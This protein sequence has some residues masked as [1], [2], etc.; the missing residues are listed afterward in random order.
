MTRAG[1]QA[2]GGGSRQRW[3]LRLR[4]GDA[5]S[6]GDPLRSC[7]A[8][9]EPVAAYSFGDAR[10]LKF[11]LRSSLSPGLP[12]GAVRGRHC[13]ARSAPRLGILRTWKELLETVRRAVCG[14]GAGHH[15]RGAGAEIER[16]RRS[17]SLPAAVHAVASDRRR[18]TFLRRGSAG[19][20]RM[21]VLELAND[22]FPERSRSVAIIGADAFTRLSRLSSP[23]RGRLARSRQIVLTVPIS[24]RSQ[25]SPSSGPRMSAV[26][27]VEVRGPRGGLSGPRRGPHW[28]SPRTARTYRGP[29]GPVLT[30]PV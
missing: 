3:R 11:A 29:R 10:R 9:G 2:T 20:S 7:T 8:W 4:Q 23:R 24:H 14:L 13:P 15:D 27:A 17:R 1:S 5:Y 6:A 21:R 25:A 16:V 22:Y 28:K 18:I 19:A 26:V 12:D 30:W